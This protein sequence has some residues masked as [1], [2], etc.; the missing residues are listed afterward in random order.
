VT[1]AARR[2]LAVAAIAIAAAACG[3]KGPPLPPLRPVPSAVTGF[4]AER[5]GLKVT[6]RFTVPDGNLDGST[7][8]SVER[9]ELHALTL[10]AESPAPAADQLVV[11][12]NLAATIAIREPGDAA[13]APPGAPADP[14][15]AAGSMA[16]HVDAA[17]RVDPAAPPAVRYYVA[18]GLAGR[19][20]GPLSAVLAVPLAAE[21]A[22]PADVAARFTE[23]ALTITWTGAAS[24]RFI[25]E[26]SD[27]K[28][29]PPVRLTPEPVG[30]A[31]FSTPVEFGRERCFLVRT[32]AGKAPV[33]V[34]GPPSAPAC[35]TPVDRFPPAA[36][37]GLLAV[38]GD[39]AV[40]LVWTAS[41]SADVGGYLVLRAEGAGGTLQR[42][43]PAPIA[44]TH[45]RDQNVRTGIVYAYVVIAVDKASPPNESAPSNRQVVTS[46]RP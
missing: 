23:Q 5:T 46:R 20:R 42:L 30:S 25:I 44:A 27:A 3:K 34:I 8:P 9:V 31:E 38:A 22:P 10:P 16:S 11:A 18:S 12:A 45:Y 33:S 4:S 17:F 15:P 29:G 37:S 39:G 1:A 28:G 41:S 43:T 32:V 24:D 14:R 21:P 13:E 7:P 6:L 40:E 26:E 19:R 36:P 35:V 2:T